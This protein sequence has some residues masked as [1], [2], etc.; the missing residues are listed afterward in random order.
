MSLGCTDKIVSCEIVLLERVVFMLGY[1]KSDIST[2]GIGD[3]VP[4]Y[5]PMYVRGDEK[6]ETVGGV[7]R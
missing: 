1:Q 4:T 3:L 5:L 6:K 2:V 7:R